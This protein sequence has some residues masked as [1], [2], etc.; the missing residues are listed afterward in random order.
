MTTLKDPP[1]NILVP[2]DFSEPSEKAAIAACALAA[3]TGATVHLLHAYVIPVE[4]VG[5][6][7]TV[8]QQYVEQFVKE[9]K[10]QLQELAAKLC[11]GA[12]LGPLLVES[13]DPREVITEEAKKL[14]AELIVMGTHGRRGITRALI[15]SV[16]ESVVRTAHCSV[17]VVR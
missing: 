3:K 15:G 13:G 9:S 2:I 8:S 16:A 6:A 12:S 1:R 17:L 14:H 11:P 5:L 4:S 7:L 10:T